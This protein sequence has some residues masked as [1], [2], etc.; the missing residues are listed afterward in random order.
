MNK[1]KKILAMFMMLIAMVNLAV[2]ILLPAFDYPSSTGMS[3]NYVLEFKNTL[4]NIA[5]VINGS[6][7]FNLI[8]PSLIIFVIITLIIVLEFFVF[9]RA[10]ISIFLKNSKC[11][12]FGKIIIITLIQA[13]IVCYTNFHGY[14]PTQVSSFIE[15]HLL[16]KNILD[17]FIMNLSIYFY[18]VLGLNLVV[19]I[20][21]IF[22]RINIKTNPDERNFETIDLF[23]FHNN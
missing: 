10:L 8:L 4:N 23:K 22:R 6:T 5:S 20:L 21:E 15:S 1:G 17:H 19:M 16:L 2:L 13:F 12:V 11:M 14:L 7:E 18:L 9:M 3:G